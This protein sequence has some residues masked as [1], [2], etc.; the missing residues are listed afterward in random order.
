MSKVN[1]DVIQDLLP[2]YID[3]ACSQSSKELIEDHLHEFE[4]CGQLLED[5]KEDIIPTPQERQENLKAIQ[6][7]KKMNRLRKWLSVSL[8]TIIGL[9]GWIYGLPY[10]EGQPLPMT[11]NSTLHY[12]I[13]EPYQTIALKNI[14]YENYL[15]HVINN[16][17]QNGN[18]YFYEIR[19]YQ[20]DFLGFYQ[21]SLYAPM[22]RLKENDAIVGNL[23]HI[24]YILGQ[25]NGKLAKVKIDFLRSEDLEFDTPDGLFFIPFE[26]P[27]DKI[28]QLELIDYDGK[29]YDTSLPEEKTLPDYDTADIDIEGNIVFKKFIYD[30]YGNV[31]GTEIVPI[32]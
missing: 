14:E 2:L 7:L 5:F 32:N 30:D 10:L 23:S 28:K 11:K 18:N 8:A 19:G 16:N 3:D 1:C 20:K 26:L 29:V 31:I 15:I 17:Y 4:P 27:L 25:N 13:S 21:E 12:L 9:L 22:M 6:P 24:G